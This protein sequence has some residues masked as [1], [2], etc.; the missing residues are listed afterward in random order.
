MFY[1][2]GVE[3]KLSFRTESSKINDINEK[4][5]SLNQITHTFIDHYCTHK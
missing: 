4:I 2:L 3:Q 5:G 1:L